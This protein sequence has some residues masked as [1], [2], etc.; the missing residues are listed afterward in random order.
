[1]RKTSETQ[2]R[3][4]FISQR[5]NA[6]KRGIGW[7]FTFEEWLLWWGDDLAYRGR[8][9]GALQ[10]QRLADSGPYRP[11]NVKKGRP[12]KNR[13]THKILVRN[14]KVAA[15]GLKHQQMLDTAPVALEEA[16]DA[17]DDGMPKLGYYT[18]HQRLEDQAVR[19]CDWDEPPTR[20]HF[21]WPE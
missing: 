16:P 11:D 10:M 20:E 21:F 13:L 8:G 15:L 4:A 3:R 18:M 19:T 12:G 5:A 14:R 17:P 7:E 9:S 2:A 1:M 6:A